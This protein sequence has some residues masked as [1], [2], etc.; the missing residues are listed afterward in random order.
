[1]RIRRLSEHSLEGSD[2]K[3][4]TGQATIVRMDGVTQDPDINIYRVQFQPTAR[5]A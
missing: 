4:F 5:T 2:P 3:T 1:M